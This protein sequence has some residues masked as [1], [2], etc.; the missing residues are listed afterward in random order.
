MPDKGRPTFGVDL[1]EQMLRDDVDVPPVVVK[2]C[3]AIERHGMTVQGIYRVGGTVSKIN[4]LKER[5]DKG[6][7][8]FTTRHRVSAQRISI[9]DLDSVNL[10]AEEW[11]SDISNVTSVLKMWLRE[12]PDPLFTTVLYQGFIEAA[13][14]SAIV[15]H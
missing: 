7:L 1:A 8:S 3:E 9:L 15:P 12:L 14:K 13:R 10:D 11:C 6:L 5:L 2:C 4:K